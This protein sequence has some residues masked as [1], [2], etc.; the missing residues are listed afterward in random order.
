LWRAE[1]KVFSQLLVEWLAREAETYRT[2]KTMPAH[3]EVSFG[4][5]YRRSGTNEPHRDAPVEVPLDDGRVLRISGQIDRIDR[6]DATEGGG[7]VL[8][9]YKTGKVP[10]D[11]DA[12]LFKGGR[13]LQIP[14]YI[15]A[16]QE[17]FP[18]EKVV[19]AF[20][21]YVNAGRQVAFNPARA[22]SATFKAL[23]LQI[24][25]LIGHGIFMQ[26]PSACTFCDFSSVCGPTPVLESRKRRR[27][28]FDPLAQKVAGL[29]DFA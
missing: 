29:K 21:D 3:F 27:R 15:L 20:L 9:D 18:G 22:T 13:Q 1:K 6:V 16:A 14:F 2:K 26:E 19:E 25:D 4:L 24:A 11:N 28:I 10:I 7:L 5:P 17:I 12:S 8:R 23:L